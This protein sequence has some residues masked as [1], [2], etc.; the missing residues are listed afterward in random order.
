MPGMAILNIRDWKG[1]IHNATEKCRIKE[2]E[3]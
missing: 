1:A 3:N 2:M